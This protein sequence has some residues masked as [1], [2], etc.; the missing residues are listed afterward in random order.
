M[1]KLK[2]EKVKRILKKP[3]LKLPTH[4]PTKFI[5]ELAKSPEQLIRDVPNPYADPIQD[6]RS[7]FFRESFEEEKRKAFGGFL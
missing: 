7:Q 3:T 4:S 1:K 6:N 2:T 5:A